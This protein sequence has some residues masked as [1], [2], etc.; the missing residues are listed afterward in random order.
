MCKGEDGGIKKTEFTRSQLWDLAKVAAGALKA[1]GLGKGDCVTHY[2]NQNSH[3]DV[4]FRL[5][6]TMLGCIPVTVNWQADTPERVI[7]KLRATKTKLMLTDSGVS[8][9]VLEHVRGQLPTLVV[10]EA[11]NLIQDG[12]AITNDEMCANL[13]QSDT[14]IIIFTSGTVSLSNPLLT[15]I[16]SSL[17]RSIRLTNHPWV[18]VDGHA[19]GSSA[20]VLV[21]RLQPLDIRG[22]S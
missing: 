22:F 6:A 9:L 21:I 4:A 17:C 20:S 3:L 8:A 19:Q 13:G 18:C 15:R 1:H 2:F 11:D 5:G 7:Y 12:T 10:G 16:A 14:R